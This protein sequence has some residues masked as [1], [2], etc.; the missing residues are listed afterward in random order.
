VNGIAL[1]QLNPED[2]CWLQL[3][4]HTDWQLQILSEP[5]SSLSLPS[6]IW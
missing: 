5:Q 3:P 4:P 6:N 2:D 1:H